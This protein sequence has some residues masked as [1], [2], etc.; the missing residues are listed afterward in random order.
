MQNESSL[1]THKERS[2]DSGTIPQESPQISNMT[3]L[4]SHAWNPNY[5]YNHAYKSV[6][7]NP[8]IY[9]IYS[10]AADKYQNLTFS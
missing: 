10:H 9:P 6:G 4:M 5:F 7:A 8:G 3:Q 1:S 2:L